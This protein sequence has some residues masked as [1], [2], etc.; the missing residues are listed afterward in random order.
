M[1]CWVL[2]RCKKKSTLQSFYS[3]SYSSVEHAVI[4]RSN[5][6]RKEKPEYFSQFWEAWAAH[7]TLGF[8]MYFAFIV[9]KVFML[10]RRNSSSG[11]SKGRTCFMQSSYKMYERNEI[12][13]PIFDTWNWRAG[14]RDGTTSLEST[15]TESDTL[16]VLGVLISEIFRFIARK[17][18]I[19]N[20]M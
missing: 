17:G 13:P 20:D 9:R 18:E 2:S 11:F 12:S 5:E 10:R 1:H 19:W 6:K 8:F 16:S 3:S 15:E 14:S 7:W 4:P